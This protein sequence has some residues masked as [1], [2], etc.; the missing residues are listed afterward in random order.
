[1]DNPNVDPIVKVNVEGVIEEGKSLTIDKTLLFVGD[2]DGSAEKTI[3]KVE[4]QVGHG[5]LLLNGEDLKVGDTFTQADINKGLLVY[6][7][8]GSEVGQDGFSFTTSD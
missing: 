2:F 3:F 8:D 6:V 5:R 4:N 1:M 7:H